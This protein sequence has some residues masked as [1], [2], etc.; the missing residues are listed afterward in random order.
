MKMRALL[1][2]VLLVGLVGFS[3]ATATAD[4]GLGNIPLH[5][6]WIE[7]SSGCGTGPGHHCS[8]GMV[9]LGPLCACASC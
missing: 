6:H 4:P 2:S 5:R 3:A 1:A 7:L 8:V 9:V